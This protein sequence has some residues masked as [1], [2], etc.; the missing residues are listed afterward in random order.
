[1]LVVDH[2]VVAHALS[3]LQR[4]DTLRRQNKTKKT[5]QD[6]TSAIKKERKANGSGGEVGEG[7]HIYKALSSLFPGNRQNQP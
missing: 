1:M 3:G 2:V 5:T 4:V 7:V 6:A